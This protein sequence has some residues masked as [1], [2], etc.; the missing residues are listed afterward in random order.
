[1]EL[2]INLGIDGAVEIARAAEEAGFSIALASDNFAT[3][4]LTVLSY[5]AA[6]T[7][8]IRLMSG[9]M[10]IP[11]RPPAT[12]ALAAASLAVLSGGRFSLGLGVSNPHVSEGWYGVPFD[13]P[14]GRTREYVRIL[15]RALAGEAVQVHGEHFRLPAGKHGGVPLALATRPLPGAMPIHLG[16]VG[17]KNLRLTG[18]IADGWIGAFCS[19]QEVRAAVAELAEGRS[20]ANATMAGFD[21]LPC[22]TTYIDEDV[23]AAADRLRDHY[24]KLLAV[25]SVDENFFCKTLTRD[26][27][28]EQAVEIHERMR[29]GDRQGAAAVVPL[30]FI[31]NTALLG[32]PARVR[33]KMTAYAEAGATTLGIMITAA[34]ADTIEKITQVHAVKAAGIAA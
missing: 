7:R 28:G 33:R 32:P 3:D 10:Q 34:K 13:A 23:E 18:E 29:A 9:V 17:P 16:A 30:E 14:L 6:S 20:A 8:R 15:R 21:V 31:D 12:T 2:A 1:M 27:F 11:A 22:V 5:V 4:A 26:G 19:P 25:G 24:A